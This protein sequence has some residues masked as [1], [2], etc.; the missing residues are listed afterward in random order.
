LQTELTR[1]EQLARPPFDAE[2]LDSLMDAAGIDALVAT[3]K[4]NVQYLLGGHRFFFFDRMDAIGQSRYL[5]IL[6]YPRGSADK[7]AYFGNAMECARRTQRSQ[8]DRRRQELATGSSRPGRRQI[9]L[10]TVASSVHLAVAGHADAD[11][12]LHE[13]QR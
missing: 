12:P 1:T 4:H 8:L 7:S 9:R 11:D 5:P 3:S 2:K 13:H 6:I 10:P